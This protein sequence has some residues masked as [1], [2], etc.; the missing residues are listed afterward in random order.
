MPAPKKAVRYDAFIENVRPDP[1]STEALVMLQGYIGKSDLAGH[2]RLYSDPTL[3]DFIELPEQDILYSDPVSTEED[4]LGG[5]RLWVRKT[6]EFT[7]G[8]PNL[9][10]RVKSSFLEGDIMKAF[11]DTMNV[12]AVVLPAV[13]PTFIT[14]CNTSF[15]PKSCC[16]SQIGTPCTQPS[17]VAPICPLTRASLCCPRTFPTP[18]NIPSVLQA[19]CTNQPSCFRTCGVACT[20]PA[21]C[22]IRTETCP[23]SVPVCASQPA[24]CP[25]KLGCPSVAVV[26]PTLACPTNP[27]CPSF[28]GCPTI[29]CQTEITIYYQQAAANQAVALTGYAGGFNPYTTTGY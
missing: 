21:L 20:A 29:A 27:E 19:T 23:P 7:A 12:P 2:I 11:G 24:G 14:V 3:S 6:T 18:C 22:G 28:A 10:N 15:R 8:D 9:I 26:C 5:S 4:P 13:L 1:K 16:V 25:T 17:L